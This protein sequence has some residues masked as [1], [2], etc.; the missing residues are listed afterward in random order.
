MCVIYDGSV[1]SGKIIRTIALI[2]V[3]GTEWFGGELAM[4][5][6]TR[7]TKF[8]IKYFCLLFSPGSKG[9]YPCKG[10]H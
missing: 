2:C 6:A 3:C 10:N 4:I 9:S 5:I 7:K 1:I 8:I